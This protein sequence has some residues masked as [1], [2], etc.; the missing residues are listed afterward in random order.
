MPKV[1]L[2]ESLHPAAR[3]A[4]D[5]DAQVVALEAP[6]DPVDDAVLAEVGIVT[7]GKAG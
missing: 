5:A 6:D 7:R 3:A 1:L 2:L 4:L